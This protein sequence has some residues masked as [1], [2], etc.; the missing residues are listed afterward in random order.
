MKASAMPRA[1]TTAL[2]LTLA[3]TAMAPPLFP[4]NAPGTG[5]ASSPEPP[6]YLSA[7][8]LAPEGEPLHVRVR[9]DTPT[10]QTTDSSDRKTF[11]T[12][13]S[14]RTHP[15]LSANPLTAFSYLFPPPAAPTMRLRDESPWDARPEPP[16][17]DNGNRMGS[18][19]TGPVRNPLITDSSA[20]PRGGDP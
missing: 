10:G 11:E 14:G 7:R 6:A 16:E 17:I 19:C 8:V 5:A 3:A 1:R 18:S 20:G 4:A 12:D 15:D 13:I 9:R 2:V